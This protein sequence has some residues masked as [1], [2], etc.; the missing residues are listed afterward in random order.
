MENYWDRKIPIFPAG[1]IELQ[2]HG[3]NL[4]FRDIYVRDISEKEYNLTPKKRPKDSFLYSMEEIWITGLAI[5]NPMLR[6]M[7]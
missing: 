6:R 4:A 5:R 7:A 1:P 2:A 3:T